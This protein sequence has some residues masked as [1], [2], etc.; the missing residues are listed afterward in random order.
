MAQLRYNWK[1]FW[2]PRGTQIDLRDNG[3]LPDPE[4]TRDN[5]EF[6]IGN[7]YN[8]NIVSFETIAN[9]PCLVLIGE[10]GIGKSN[11]IQDAFNQVPEVALAYLTC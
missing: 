6:N 4:S 1:R 3:Y 2:Y 11:A 8:P 10:P 9:I 7:F 5:S